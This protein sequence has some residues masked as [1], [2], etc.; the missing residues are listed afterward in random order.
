[1]KEIRNITTTNSAHVGV[2]APTRDGLKIPVRTCQC[3]GEPFYR[4]L[5]ESWTLYERRKYCGNTCRHAMLLANNNTPEARA[6]ASEARRYKEED[7]PERYCEFCGKRLVPRHTDAKR[8]ILSNFMKRRYCDMACGT[9]GAAMK[10][11]GKTHMPK[12]QPKPP[13][14]YRQCKTHPEIWCSRDGKFW[15]N[16]K[17]KTVTK[18]SSLFN[19]HEYRVVI[20]EKNRTRNV[21]TAAQLVAEAWIA[22]YNPD[23]YIVYK[24]GDPTNYHASNIQVVD[25]KSYFAVRYNDMTEHNPYPTYTDQL[26]IIARTKKELLIVEDYFHSADFSALHKY[27]KDELYFSLC[28]YCTKSLKLGLEETQTQVPNVI[29]HVYDVL[30][31]GHAITDLTRY[32]EARLHKYSRLGHYGFLMHIPKKI[33]MIITENVSLEELWNKFKVTQRK[34]R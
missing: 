8:E 14:G 25:K 20:Y 34:N 31:Q 28:E 2:T 16:G 9:K 13:E 23:K 19:R 24:D 6:K 15:R 17:E 7:Y 27:V 32:C 22:G 30:L 5:H 3:C 1:M 10:N 18:K 33:E 21:V 12:S 11:R 29:A 26:K 4:R